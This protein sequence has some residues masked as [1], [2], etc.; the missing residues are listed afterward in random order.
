MPDARAV[1]PFHNEAGNR[2]FSHMVG[3]I[4]ISDFESFRDVLHGQLRLTLQKKQ[5]LK[6]P[7]IGESFDDSFELPV[8]TASSHR[9]ILPYASLLQ[10]TSIANPTNL[11]FGEFAHTKQTRRVED[12]PERTL[13]I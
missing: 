2:E 13:R 5:D 11:P 9:C 10:N 7:V 4:L 3:R 12:P 1:V 8:C 6:P